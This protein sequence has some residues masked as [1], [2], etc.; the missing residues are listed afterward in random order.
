MASTLEEN[1][2]EKDFRI[3]TSLGSGGFGEVKLACHIP[4]C[5]QVAVKVLE[6]KKNT[7][8]S[9]NT[10]VEIL[11]SVE[12][13]NIVNF[14]HV[15]DTSS[16]TFVIMEYIAGKDLKYF[17]RGKSILKEDEVRPIFQQVVSGVHFL[18]QN[19]IAHRD[20]K[21]ENILIDRAGNIKLCDFGMARQLAE[22]QMMV[23]V[24]GT[25]RYLAPEIL[26]RKPYD[27]LVGDMWSLGVLL[28]VLVTGKFPYVESTFY[29]MYK[30]ITTTKYPIPYYLSEP[31][32]TIIEQLLTVPTQNR[33]TIC[34]LQESE[35]LGN[36]KQPEPPATKELLPRVVEA[37]CTMGYTC[38]D[39]VSTI[40]HRQPSNLTATFNILKYKLSCGDSLQQNQKPWLNGSHIGSP[41]LLLPLKRRAS[42]PAFP[43]STEE[44]KRHFHE[45]GVEGRA[46]RCQSYKMLNSNSCQ[47]IKPCSD[48][49]V[50]Q[51]DVRMANVINSTPA[52]IAI[53]MNSVE[54][55]PSDLSSGESVPDGTRTRFL[56]MDFSTEEP[57]MGHNMPNDQHKVQTTSLGS[58]PI[59]GWKLRKK[60]ISHA[61]RAL[62]SCSM[63]TAL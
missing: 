8:T 45:E 56:N 12:H 39:I 36:I 30:V 21:L 22:G 54:S 10:E 6:K 2:L 5:T 17:L 31:C 13:R 52:L 42:I 1:T 44:G 63:P 24:C 47:K 3:L 27:G 53:K 57:F 11:Q 32:L 23:K 4:T 28:Y 40:K 59:R 7:L 50:S 51:A 18:H 58:R 33:I 19:R 15:I 61:L 9:I 49:T 60:R 20:I 37:M 41:R 43:P 48:G 34:Q 38:E 26:A 35:W 14:F 29:G 16:T 62:F 55:L 25:L 46:R